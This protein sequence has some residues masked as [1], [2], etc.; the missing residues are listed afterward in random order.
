ML[1]ERG[2]VVALTGAGISVES[3]I[4]AFRG[5]QGLWEKYAPMEYATIGAFIRNP[6]KS[7]L[8]L[9]ELFALC[10]GAS[11]NAAHSGLADLESMGLLR[12][13]ITQNVDRLHQAAGTRRVIEY[14]G[15]MEE[16][17]CIS[18]WRNYPTRERWK[19]DGVP[20][21]CDCGEILKP[22]IVMFGEPIPWIAQERAEEEAR[23]CAVLLVI[24]TSAQ[25][26]PA[27]DIPRIAKR[28]GAAVVEINPEET[29]LTGTVTDIHISGSASDAV[30]GLLDS[31]SALRTG[32]EFPPSD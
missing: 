7:W 18:C 28:A 3:G 20:P 13:V 29:R 16:L 25:V 31:V 26:T 10:G 12:A 23:S 32:N 14:H 2:N 19:G 30:R 5:A 8:M 9:T 15:N 22:N 17:V 4:P 24:G 27:C 11:P 6:E 1:A 21:R